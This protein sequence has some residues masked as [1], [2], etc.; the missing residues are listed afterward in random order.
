MFCLGFFP[1]GVFLLFFFGVGVQSG[2]T[3][4][5]EPVRVFLLLDNMWW[6]DGAPVPPNRVCGVVEWSDSPVSQPGIMYGAEVVG[7]IFLDC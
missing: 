2:S 6:D 5:R 1:V 7:S 4:K 3:S